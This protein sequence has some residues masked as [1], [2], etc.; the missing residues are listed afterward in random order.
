MASSCPFCAG[1]ANGETLFEDDTW[2]LQGFGDV[3]GWAILWLRRHAEGIEELTPA[4]LGSLGPTVERV[5]AAI[6][7]ATGAERV[8]LQV[9]GE[10]APHFH[11][12]LLARGSGVTAAHRGPALLANAVAYADAD[13]ARSAN[14]SVRATLAPPA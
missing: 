14:E 12:V 4:E 11:V 13:A 3:P 5:S 8:Y 6:R 1:G 7:R 10:A 9:Y 2:A